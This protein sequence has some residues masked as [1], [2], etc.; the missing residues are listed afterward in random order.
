MDL[1]QE[2]KLVLAAQQGDEQ[3]FGT[4]YDAF[5]DKVYRY[6]SYRVDNPEIAHD[7]TAEVFLRVVEGLPTYEDRGKTFLAWL[8]RIAHARLIDYYRQ[9]NHRARQV[10]LEDAEFRIGNDMDDMDVGL[11]TNYRQEQIRGALDTLTDD[12]QQV[13]WMRFMEG[14]NL[15]ET[16]K[17]LGKTVGAIKLLQY[18]AVQSLSRALS[19]KGLNLNQG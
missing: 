6:L 13:I 14:H 12:Q 9:T 19:T 8:Y 16:A 5:V 11:M 7:L 2:Q 18:R 4:L 1:K 10:S 15:E 17:L 3:A